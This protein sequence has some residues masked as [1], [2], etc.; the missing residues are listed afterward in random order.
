MAVRMPPNGHFL[1]WGT[2]GLIAALVLRL[3]YFQSTARRSFSEN[4][5]C[6]ELISTSGAAPYSSP[7]TKASRADRG[8]DKQKALRRNGL[9]GLLGACSGRGRDTCG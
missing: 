1:S 6:S 9:F 4:C 2:V 3:K 5:D 7:K 8:A